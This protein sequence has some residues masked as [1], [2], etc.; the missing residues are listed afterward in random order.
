MSISRKHFEAIAK[1]IGERDYQ[2]TDG[3]HYLSEAEAR[4]FRIALEL[5]VQDLGNMFEDENENFD[6]ERFHDACFTHAE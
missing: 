1:I 2:I 3:Q 6:Y 5:I 4:G